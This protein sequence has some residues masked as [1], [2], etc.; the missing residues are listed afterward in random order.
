MDLLGGELPLLI[1]FTL[2]M[3]LGLFLVAVSLYFSLMLKTG[4]GGI[5]YLGLFSI[6]LGLWKLTD[7][8]CMPLLLPEY[9]M[10]IGYISVGSLFLTGLC[11]LMY[12][13]TLFVNQSQGPLLLLSTGGSLICLYALVSQVFGITEIRQ[14]LVFSHVLLITAIVSI[15]LAALLNRIIHKNWGI[16]RSWRLLALLFV[17]IGADLLLYYKNNGNG[18]M[19]FSIMGFILYTLIVF[20]RSVQDSTRKAYT[21]TRTGLENRTR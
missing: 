9:S 1:L 11:L 5:S 8:K 15:P 4:N 17:G 19:S 14:N 18:L 16:Q 13:R 20:L 12:F 6:F 10:A 21:D 7:L 3:L 2:C